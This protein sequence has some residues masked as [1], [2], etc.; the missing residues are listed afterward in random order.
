M[1][2]VD[3]YQLAVLYN[4]SHR[5][6]GALSNRSHLPH[7]STT[8]P[9]GSRSSAANP[10]RTH[11]PLPSS[12]QFA[13]KTPER[14]RNATRSVPGPTPVSH[15]TC[16]LQKLQPDTDE[17]ETYD[18]AKYER[19][20]TQDFERHRVFVDIDVFMKHV[21]HVPEDWED[22]WGR[23]IR[24]VR[25]DSV[26]SKAQ[27]KYYEQCGTPGVKECDLYGPLIAMGNAI[28][29]LSTTSNDAVI[30]RT[31]QRYLRN[32]P[33]GILCGVMKDLSPDI[34]A[35]HEDFLPHILPEERETGCLEQS[36]LTWAQPLQVL[37]VKPWDGALVD[38]SCMPKLKVNG[39]PATISLDTFS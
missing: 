11:L 8:A 14:K 22:L 9:S 38:G 12:T 10:N 36:N 6:V 30:P 34:V 13:L 20:I 19:Y 33:K 7:M 32:D 16:V 21:L 39:K 31:P 4:L 15:G 28:L 18:S 3:F 1:A 26:F 2:L 23:T 17:E 25:R 27:W 35:V 24:R 37:E 29:N 5:D